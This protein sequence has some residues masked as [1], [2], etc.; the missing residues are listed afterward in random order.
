M[1]QIKKEYQV[2]PDQKIVKADDY[3]A[4][5]DSQT[6]ISNAQAEADEILE[7]AKRVF[8][9]EK[10][11]GYEQGLKEG[12]KKSTA[13]LIKYLSK[14]VD[15]FE[16]FEEKILDVVM[17]ALRQIMGEMDDKELV[18]KIVKKALNLAR[19]QKQMVL[20]VAPSQAEYMRG[21]IDSILKDY[22]GI[23]FVDVREDARLTE[24]DCI[25]DTDLGVIDGRI[26]TQLE[27]L[28]TT[29]KDLIK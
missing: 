8:E 26:D 15:S 23:N 21:E 6:I 10:V 13:H 11:K 5:V 27:V 3:A 25:V 20:R 18:K 28:R 2:L 19:S 17:K 16:K 4:F 9:E 12:E 22:P 29:F 7:D 14:T 24:G 1:L